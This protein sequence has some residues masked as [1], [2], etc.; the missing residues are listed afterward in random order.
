LMLKKILKISNDVICKS[1]LFCQTLL[2]I[3]IKGLTV[4]FNCD[5]IL[6]YINKINAEEFYKTL[7]VDTVI[8]ARGGSQTPPLAPIRALKVLRF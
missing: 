7:A 2:S 1:L 4:S 8:K 6:L 3:E 5:R